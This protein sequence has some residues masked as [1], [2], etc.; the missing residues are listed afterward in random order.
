MIAVDLI[1][2]RRIGLWPRGS[3]FPGKI[4]LPVKSQ[5]IPPMSPT[6]SEL[7]ARLA[8]KS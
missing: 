1:T 7:L 5:T 6:W 4:L 3:I 2:D 8:Q